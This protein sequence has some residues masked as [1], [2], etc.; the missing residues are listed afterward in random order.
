[1]N[2][3]EWEELLSEPPHGHNHGRARFDQ[4]G[5]RPLETDHRD[6]PSIK[7]PP[8]PTKHGT[9]YGY[10]KQKCRCEFCKMWESD[11]RREYRERM[12]QPP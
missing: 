8:V 2:Y 6:E 9:A 5:W 1:M 7:R 10:V 12:S 3:D 4:P 11:R